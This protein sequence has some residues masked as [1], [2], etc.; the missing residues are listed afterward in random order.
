MSSPSGRSFFGSV[1]DKLSRKG[2]NRSI[3][4]NASTHSSRDLDHPTNPFTGA[5]A[6]A[7]APTPRGQ[8]PPPSYQEATGGPTI[9]VQ[10]PGS[11]GGGGRTSSSSRISA[12]SVTTPDD[13]FAFLS[14]FDTV[15]LIDDSG[16]MAGKSWAEVKSALRSITPT[17]TSHDADGIDVFFLNTLNSH[18]PQGGWT[19]ITKPKQVEELFN[20][21]KPGKGTP[22]GTRIRQILNPY[23]REY[24]RA[25][26]RSGDPD[27]SGMK[28]MNMIV[29]T[30]GV[31]TDDPESTIISIAKKLDKLEA[32]P[33]Q[34]GIQFFQVGNE[35]GAAEALQ[36]LDDNLGKEAGLRDM[37]DTVT[38]SGR[39]RTQRVLTA[40]GILKVVL[41]A[42][43][44]RLDRKPAGGEEAGPSRYRLA[45]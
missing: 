30:D 15:F 8:A 19:C 9:T 10:P 32:P 1:K 45:P 33:Y 14:T 34:V 36:E 12:A 22:T 29:I 5:S 2:S 39:D 40:D 37:V 43:V 26:A 4:S 18:H 28:P 42:V 24:E 7:P 27:N 25:I 23:L 3:K 20:Q 35:Y 21:V 13:P 11:G 44:R 38:W 16:S 17:C 6:L 31:A 41:G